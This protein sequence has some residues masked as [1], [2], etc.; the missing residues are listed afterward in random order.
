MNALTEFIEV[1]SGFWT[2]GRL[3][4]RRLHGMGTMDL[5]LGKALRAREER[6]RHGLD[7][8]VRRI[9]EQRGLPPQMELEDVVDLLFALT[10]FETFDALGSATRRPRNVAALIRRLATFVALGETSRI[11]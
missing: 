3:L 7:V 10:S 4:L 9:A 11:S 8:L 5:E 2:S 6:R 1:F